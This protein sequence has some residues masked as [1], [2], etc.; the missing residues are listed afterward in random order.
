MAKRIERFDS[1]YRNRSVSRAHRR[2]LGRTPLLLLLV[3]VAACSNPPRATTDPTE[4]T[5]LASWYSDSLHGRTT[6]SGEAYDR[7]AMTAAH[8]TLGFGTRVRVTRTSSGRSVDVT[9]NDR[10][11]F[12]DG[13]IIDL[14]RR[15]A[16]QL[17][18]L[19]DGVVRVRVVVLD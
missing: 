10:G 1:T 6:A 13:R 12:V 14:S 5:G 18:M 2:H 17:G 9:I 11:P 7:D 15:A 4:Q 16:E 3:F 8:R 19:E